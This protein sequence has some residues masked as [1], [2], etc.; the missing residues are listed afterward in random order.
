MWKA[1]VLAYKTWCSWNLRGWSDSKNVWF[2]VCFFMRRSHGIFTVKHHLPTTDKARFQTSHTIL[3]D[4]N[5]FFK[6]IACWVSSL[7]TSSRSFDV[8]SRSSIR[9]I[10]WNLTGSSFKLF[11]DERDCR[12]KRQQGNLALISRLC[13]GKILP[14]RVLNLSTFSCLWFY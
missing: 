8:L 7:L 5:Y 14:S 3:V 4:I 2:Q 13:V 10:G 1:I 11:N 6:C 9:R 12:F